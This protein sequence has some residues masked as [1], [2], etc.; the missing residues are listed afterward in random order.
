MHRTEAASEFVK[1]MPVI[2]ALAG[3]L[4]PVSNC[5]TFTYCGWSAILSPG[6]FASTPEGALG[7]SEGA[8]IG[9]WAL[10]SDLGQGNRST[11]IVEEV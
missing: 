6:A 4:D 5:A 10:A 9:Q 3:T 11:D 2:W 1:A 7:K 8:Q